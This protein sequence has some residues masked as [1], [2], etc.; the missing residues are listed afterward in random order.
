MSYTTVK[1][2]LNR[3]AVE[4]GQGPVDDPFNNADPFFGTLRYLLMTAGEE[5]VISNSWGDLIQTITFDE[6]SIRNPDGGFPL[7]DD[8]CYLIPQT[9]WDTLNRL[10]VFGPMSA[11]EWTT[12][13][14]LFLTDASLFTGLRLFKGAMYLY[15]NPPQNPTPFNFTFEYV[16]QNWVVPVGGGTANTFTS[17]DDLVMYDRTL[18]TRYLKLKYLETAG[19]DTDKAQAD[20][21]QVYDFLLGRD[22][23]APVLNAGRNGL[24]FPYLSGR[25]VPFTGFGL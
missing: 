13:E 24:T 7:P 20:F 1:D 4:C 15:P 19:F 3:A 18:I 22:K 23:S 6:N 25:N 8:Y 12:A 14:G 16:S 21:N 10:P 9:G 17:G 11:Q 5:L 2:I